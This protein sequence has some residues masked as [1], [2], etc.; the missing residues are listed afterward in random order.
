[1]G[2]ESFLQGVEPD[3]VLPAFGQTF[4]GGDALAM[5]A[6]GRIDAGQHRVTVH[7]DRAGTAFGLVAADLGAGQAQAIAQQVRQGFPWKRRQLVFLAVN[8]KRDVLIHG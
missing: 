6:L 8:G 7:H 5:G 3:A 1:M 2:D 4:D